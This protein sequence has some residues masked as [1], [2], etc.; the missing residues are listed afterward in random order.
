M[1]ITLKEVFN[2]VAAIRGDSPESLIQSVALTQ[3]LNRADMVL[4]ELGTFLDGAS[5][6]TDYWG[7]PS[8][9]TSLDV[10]LVNENI[11]G[12]VVSEKGASQ[13]KDSSMFYVPMK[14][15]T[16]M[17]RVYALP[18]LETP[19]AYTFSFFRADA[20]DPT[21][22]Y[23][24]GEYYQG[25]YS[26]PSVID[27]VTPEALVYVGLKFP[28]TPGYLE[29]PVYTGNYMCFGTFLNQ[30]QVPPTELVVQVSRPSLLGGFKLEVGN[31][32]TPSRE[33]AGE[34]LSRISPIQMRELHIPYYY[35]GWT[36]ARD[37]AITNALLQNLPL[38]REFGLKHTACYEGGLSLATRLPN[39]FLIQHALI[40][41]I[42]HA[43]DT[44][45]EEAN[46]PGGVMRHRK[47]EELK[48]MY[49]SQ[50]LL[51]R[52]TLNRGNSVG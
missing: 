47:W 38:P 39:A 17:E 2:K 42:A 46:T 24:E 30:Y 37:F 7:L 1:T 5:L 16:P 32:A 45:T 13:H 28:N 22:S 49:T 44:A 21:I 12:E 20:S 43:I 34:A 18:V 25:V 9:C 52:A 40:Y 27:Y 29:I 6:V 41:G 8:G 26:D 4:Q 51:R 15:Y 11:L 14:H 35:G 50:N 33:G 48:T 3:N 10:S 31:V 23:G 19:M 36:S